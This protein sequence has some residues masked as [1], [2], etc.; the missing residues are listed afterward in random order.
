MFFCDPYRIQTCNLL[1]RS[2]M[3]YS[4]ELRGLLGSLAASIF[5]FLSVESVLTGYSA[6]AMDAP[7]S[8]R[9]ATFFSLILAFLPESF[10]R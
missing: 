5:L 2:K 7:S 9:I 3:L 10:L 8:F 4:V 1:I 6:A